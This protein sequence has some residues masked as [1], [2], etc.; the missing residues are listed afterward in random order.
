MRLAALSQQF[1]EY[2]PV[3][4]DLA[5]GGKYGC[6]MGSREA[7]FGLVGVVQ[8]V[9]DIGFQGTGNAFDIIQ[10]DIVFRAFDRT[11]IAAIESAEFSEH[12]L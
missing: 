2:F 5:G 4:D 11:D 1:K 3:H 9:G 8:Q 12:F 6:V 10:T 7:V